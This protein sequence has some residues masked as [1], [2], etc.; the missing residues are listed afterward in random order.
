MLTDE[1]VYDRL[2]AALLALG[3]DAG[4]TARGDTALKAGRRS[5]TMLQMA[6]LAA[7]EGIR[8]QCEES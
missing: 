2:H 8:L 4:E 3:G 1:E 6:L 5:L 7:I